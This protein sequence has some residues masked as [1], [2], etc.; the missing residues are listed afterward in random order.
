MLPTSHPTR[1]RRVV[2]IVALCWLAAIGCGERRARNVP[3]SG[4]VQ[5]ADGKVVTFGSVQFHPD[6]TRGNGGIWPGNMMPLHRSRPARCGR[7]WPATT[8]C[9]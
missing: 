9:T 8:Q 7:R 3:V 4:R 2:Q 5:F 1:L 6:P